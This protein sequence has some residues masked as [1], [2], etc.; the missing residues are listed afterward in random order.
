MPTKLLM[1][2]SSIFLGILGGILSFLPDEI[3]SI[4]SIRPNPIS[5]LSFQLMGA[6]YFGFAMLNWMSKDSLIGGIYKKPIAIGNFMHFGIGGLALIKITSKIQGHLE[7]VITLTIIYAIFALLF[8]YVFR[9][10][11]HQIK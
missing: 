9:T 6:L 1:I 7:I 5:T 3:I 11:P 4:L 8:G 2:S 10:N